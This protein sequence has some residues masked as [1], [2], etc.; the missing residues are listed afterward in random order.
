MTQLLTNFAQSTL[1][2]SLSNSATSFSV[3]TGD[4]TKFPNPSSPDYFFIVV[5]EGSTREVMKVTARSTDSFSTVVRAQQGTSASA[6]S[7]G[8]FVELRDTKQIMDDQPLA[9]QTASGSM[10]LEDFNTLN[11]RRLCLV[12]KD[13]NAGTVSAVGCYAPTL[14]GGSSSDSVDGPLLVFVTSTT[15]NDFKGIEISH[16]GAYDQFRRDWKV[17]IK[18]RMQLGATITTARWHTGCYSGNPQ[19]NAG[20]LAS[21][22]VGAGFRYD[23]TA[24]GTA[25]WRTI[26]CGGTSDTVTDTGVA[27]TASTAYDLLIE[28]DTSEIRFY[29]N[30]VKVTTHTT[31]L[32]SSTQLIAPVQMV[33]TLSTVARRTLFGR[34]IWDHL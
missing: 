8:A 16:A 30:G 33:T 5:Q 29:I 14:T 13:V 7:A 23:T 1:P 32:P 20:L 34:W 21:G 10:T 6:F 22:L 19:A 24:D 3:Q 18:M 15:T 12:Y 25:N 4:G 31:N 28:F 17:R 27:F 2:S 11:Y 26:T 9:S